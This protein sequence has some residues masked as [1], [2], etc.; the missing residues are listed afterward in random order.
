MASGDLSQKKKNRNHFKI[1]NLFTHTQTETT[2]AMLAMWPSH[3]IFSFLFVSTFRI[4]PSVAWNCHSDFGYF[5][6]IISDIGHNRMVCLSAKSYIIFFPRAYAL[7]LTA[8]SRQPAFSSILHPW[9]TI[10][11]IFVSYLIILPHHKKKCKHLRR[12]CVCVCVTQANERLAK[13]R[14]CMCLT[15]H[16]KFLFRRCRFKIDIS[17]VS[18]DFF[19]SPYSICSFRTWKTVHFFIRNGSA[20][21]CLC[22]A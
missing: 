21:K 4:S 5:F 19:S 13:W 20:G 14:W 22:T 9:L 15:L 10:F 18:Q 1:A 3:R 12:L 17:T 2:L 11:T 6:V 7:A 16:S 8:G